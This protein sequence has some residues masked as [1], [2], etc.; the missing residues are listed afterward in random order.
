MKRTWNLLSCIGFLMGAGG[1]FFAIM[2]S[3]YIQNYYENPDWYDF[4][5]VPNYA[6]GAIISAAVAFFG[7]YM[8]YAIYINANRWNRVV[9]IAKSQNRITLK[10]VSTKAGIP[11]EKI[12][13]IIYDAI[14]SGDLNGT[15][16]GEV[17]SKSKPSASIPTSGDAKVLVICPYCGAKTEQ[18]FSKCQKC[19]ADI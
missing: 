17:F 19:G 8:I 14:G 10:E 6:V 12:S 3:S 2:L 1:G 13:D 4:S 7:L 15:L 5:Y 18:G 16:E 9:S 11:T